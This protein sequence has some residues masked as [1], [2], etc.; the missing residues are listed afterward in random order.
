MRKIK[1]DS[2]SLTHRATVWNKAN[3]L[4]V[5]LLAAFGFDEPDVALPEETVWESLKAARGEGVVLDEG[6]GKKCAEFLA[7]GECFAP[8]GSPVERCDVS[9]SVAG[10][11]KRLSVVGDRYWIGRG[12]MTEATDPA[13][14]VRMPITW[15]RAFGGP[16]YAPNPTGRGAGSVM[17]PEGQELKPLPNVEYPGQCVKSPDDRPQPACFDFMGARRFCTGE[18]LGTYDFAWLAEHWPHAAPDTA[19]AL[20]NC[21]AKDQWHGGYY[22]GGEEVLIVNMHPARPRIQ[23]RLPRLRARIFCRREIYGSAAYE[24]F[25]PHLDT[26]WLLPGQEVMVCIWRAYCVASYPDARDVTHLTAAFEPL[27]SGPE[28]KERYTALIEVPF[29]P[30]RKW[31]P[32]ANSEA[33][34]PEAP[35]PPGVPRSTLARDEAL[36]LFAAGRPL[37]GLDLTGL[38]LTHARLAGADLRGAILQ[39]AKLDGCDLAEA[40]LTGAIL[41]GASA[42]KAVFAKARLKDASAAGIYAPEADFTAS[43]A[44]GA[45]LTGAVLHKADL[46][47]CALQEACLD[48]ADLGEADFSRCRAAK[49]RFTGCRA[50]SAV[51]AGADLAGADLTRSELDRAVFR[52]ASLTKALLH[53]AHGRDVSFAGADLSRAKAPFAAAFPGADFTGANLAGSVFGCCDLSGAKFTGCAAAGASFRE[54]DMAS[55]C[56]RKASLKLACLDEADLTRADLRHANLFKASLRQAVLH[57]A[58]LSG[59]N[60]YGADFY[61]ARFMETVLAGADLK[62]TLLTN[63]KAVTL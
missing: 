15:E 32:P 31:S 24:E 13:P 46:S 47:G 21:A 60:C 50:A 25:D 5:S 33:Q 45:D 62:A 9:V 6:F 17:H 20:V 35:K 12:I 41:T 19:H 56:F 48:E 42:A 26:L 51:F 10:T 18:G 39:D 7:C 37:A 44:A 34:G 29:E 52:D 11:T 54:C 53:E 22:T 59:S 1:P 8:G 27:S 58:D 16:G 49:A 36:E 40:D 28:P 3:L 30:A 38:D 43:D 2:L 57:L 61:K 23:T 55:A 4:T 14:F 63:W